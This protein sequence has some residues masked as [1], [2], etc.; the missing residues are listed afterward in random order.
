MKTLEI[1]NKEYKRQILRENYEEYIKNYPT[2]YPG[3]PE[4]FRE[5]VE[6]ESQSDP[7]FWNWL[8][9]PEDEDFIF[10]PDREEFEEFLSTL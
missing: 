10:C 4:S 7:D 1:P 6:L 2:N 8:F 3:T 9:K 5:W